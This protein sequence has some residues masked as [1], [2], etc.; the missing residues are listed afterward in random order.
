M[1][2][3]SYFGMA[4][5]LYET[6]WNELP[7]DQQKY[8]IIMIQ[9]AQQPLYYHGYGMVILKLETFCKVNENFGYFYNE[10]FFEII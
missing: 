8:F 7:I 1:S 3:E 5:C 6:N 4:E 2:T 9:N 10:H